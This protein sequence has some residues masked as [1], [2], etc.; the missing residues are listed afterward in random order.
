MRLVKPE[1]QALKK[2]NDCELSILDAMENLVKARA[3]RAGY[4]LRVVVQ[5]EIH[6][7]GIALRPV[8]NC[9]HGKSDKGRSACSAGW[10]RRSVQGCRSVPG[11][12][13]GG[14]REV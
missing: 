5:F 11:R 14:Y 8:G 6:R 13:N 7:A 9:G 4:P 10:I 12:T 1:S 2:K 3:L